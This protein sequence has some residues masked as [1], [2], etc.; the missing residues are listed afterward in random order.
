MENP[1]ASKGSNV[2]RLQRIVDVQEA[3][4]KADLNL[5]GLMQIIVNTLQELTHAKGA[6]V[7]LVEGDYMVYR[8]ASGAISQFAG[9]RLLRSGSLSGLSVASAEVLRCDDTETDTRV[10]REACRKV[11][12]RSMVCTPLFR[13]GT[14]V[15]VLK[16]MS[17]KPAGFDEDGVQTLNLLAGMLGAALGK[18]LAFDA[19]QHAEARIRLIL[20]NAK[21][22]V[23]STNEAGTIMLWNCAAE[24]LF[25]W[26]T[27]EAVGRKLSELLDDDGNPIGLVTLFQ[28]QDQIQEDGRPAQPTHRELGVR[29]R[30]GTAMTVEFNLERNVLKDGSGQEDTDS[31]EITAFLHDITERKRLEQSMQDM[32]LTDELTG[33]ANRR[34]IMSRLTHAIVRGV[35]QNISMALLFMDMN[36]FKQ[37]N[38]RYGHDVGDLVLQEFAKRLSSCLREADTVGRLGG[39]EFVVLA[40]GID[41]PEHAYGL[42]DKIVEALKPPM[43]VFGLP[44]E[45]SI[46]ISL[47]HPHLPDARHE[48]ADQWLREAD[49]AMYHAKHQKETRNRIAICIDGRMVDYQPAA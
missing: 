16:V 1:V 5:D 26:S 30:D 31:T 9:L 4:V 18:Q 23:I 44:L 27:R 14:P 19:L 20:E 17:D 38:D 47:H 37:I 6:V 34:S 2:D 36:G 13:S 21:D 15:G 46:G 7:E 24:K 40:E 12:V 42:A 41:S 32:A 11:G 3:I 8:S 39:D 33:L 48:S 45:T 25:G 49:M 29:A 28:T 35:R 22:A 43:P 10:D